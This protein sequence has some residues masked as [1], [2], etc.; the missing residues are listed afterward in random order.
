MPEGACVIEFTNDFR[1]QVNARV[2]IPINAK[3]GP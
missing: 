3:A 1:H 2:H